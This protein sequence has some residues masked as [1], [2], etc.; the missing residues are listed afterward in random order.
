M[1]NKT[2]EEFYQMVREYLVEQGKATSAEFM[3]D[4]DRM[5]MNGTF[6]AD[7][8]KKFMTDNNITIVD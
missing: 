7:D 8:M 6:S 5:I 1:P 4:A 3:G 2:G